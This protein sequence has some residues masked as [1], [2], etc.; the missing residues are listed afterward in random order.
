MEIYVKDNKALS[1][2]SKFLTP[3]ASGETWIIN[4]VPDTSE[5]F[6]YDV[7]FTSN[8][9]KCIE[10]ASGGTLAPGQTSYNLQYRFDNTVA[11]SAVYSPE[12]NRWTNEAYRTITFL[13]PP[14]GDLL[15]WLQANG[16]KQ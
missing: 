15:T 6:S 14:T 11:L 4:E 8:E 9:Q 10:I 2:N 7:Q 13:A 3:A 5:Q 12:F 1:L 16:T